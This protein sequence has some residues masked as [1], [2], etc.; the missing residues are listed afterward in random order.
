MNFEEIVYLPFGNNVIV[1]PKIKKQLKFLKEIIPEEFKKKE[2]YD[3]GCG[4]GKVTLK[5]KNI[6]C[7]K[8]I[9][10]CDSNSSLIWRAKR[11]GIEARVLDLE[12]E[13]PKGELA[14]F[15]GVLHHLKNQEKVLKRIKNNF[16]YVFL[17]EPLI[18]KNRKSLFEVGNP[19]FETEIDKLLEK[20]LKNFK[21]YKY[22]DSIFIFWKR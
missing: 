4:D 8:K 12:R 2:L 10:G 21:K 15:W 18:K 19:F 17:R 22:Q 3:L 16:Q 9:Y 14:V 13:I 20:T 1:G 7:P 6:F 5:L 11:K